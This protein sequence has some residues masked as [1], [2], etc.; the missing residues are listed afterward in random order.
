MQ[1]NKSFSQRGKLKFMLLWPENLF[2]PSSGA[3]LSTSATGQRTDCHH[4]PHSFRG[5]ISVHGLVASD[6]CVGIN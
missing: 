1:Y 2:G 5:N 4:Q 3:Q 6:F